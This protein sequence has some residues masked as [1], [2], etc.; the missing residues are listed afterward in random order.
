MF[1]SLRLGIEIELVGTSREK[2]AQAVQS[3]VGGNI[4][5][6]LRS[7]SIVDSRNRTWKVVPD[8][9]L[10]GGEYSG[11]VISPIL[12][13]ADVEE[14]QRVVRALRGAGSRAD[15]STGIHLHISSEKLDAPAIVRL[16]KLVHKREALIQAALGVEPSRLARYCQPIDPE[17][18][19]RIEA[20]PPRTMQE[21]SDAWYG[22][23]IERA[24]RYSSTRYRTININSLFVRGTIE[25]RCF[26]GT[27]HAGEVKAW[28]Q[29]ALALVNKAIES[30]AASSRKQTYDSAS[31]KYTMR[32]WL[33]AL[34]MS[35]ESFRTARFHLLKR[36]GGSTAWKGERRDRR[37]TQ[38][39]IP[40]QDRVA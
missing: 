7:H 1:D 32:T 35:G 38:A 19:Q 15:S 39:P 37:Q 23:R 17:F 18:L 6:E 30:K 28:I 8:G 14:V 36:L 5:R 2:M 10:S 16:V 25:I 31:S 34:G 33:L 4:N 24:D 27:T 20:R 21:L 22:R 11:E 9:S 26:N 3:V 12:T 29:L 40:R 13:Y